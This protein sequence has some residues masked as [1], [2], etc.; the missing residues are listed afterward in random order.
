VAVTVSI[1]GGALEELHDP[2]MPERS[3]ADGERVAVHRL[4][5]PTLKVAVP[6]GAVKPVTVAL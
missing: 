4:V 5:W 3:V 2:L 6:L 1:P